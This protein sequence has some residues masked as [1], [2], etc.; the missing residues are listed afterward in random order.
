MRLD[1]GIICSA[2]NYF[3]NLDITEEQIDWD[4]EG[5]EGLISMAEFHL[6][7]EILAAQI[8]YYCLRRIRGC[9]GSMTDAMS[10]I[11]GQKIRQYKATYNK[12]FINDNDNKIA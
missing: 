4:E 3:N 10:R 1:A 9:D 12:E 2:T 5:K 11:I 7:E 6:I 8:G